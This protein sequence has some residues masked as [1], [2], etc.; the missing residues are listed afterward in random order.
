LSG[1]P[2]SPLFL[3]WAMPN[4]MVAV[5]CDWVRGSLNMFGLRYP[6]SMYQRSNLLRNCSVC[7]TQLQRC[8]QPQ[9]VSENDQSN[10]GWLRKS[11]LAKYQAKVCD[12]PIESQQGR[13]RGW[14][15]TQLSAVFL[16]TALRLYSCWKVKGGLYIE[17]YL[18]VVACCIC[19]FM[20]SLLF[21]SK[22][23]LFPC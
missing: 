15:I 18:I 14:L 6:L 23:Q 2:P 3:P 19:G 22:C 16:T 4:I 10:L 21:L 9:Y 20:S 12:R 8:R 1:K 13:V 5:V 7:A 11:E 17:D